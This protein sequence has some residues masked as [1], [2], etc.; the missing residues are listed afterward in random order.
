MLG[1]LAILLVAIFLPGGGL[2]AI[3]LHRWMHRTDRSVDHDQI[4]AY[5]TRRA[6]QAIRAEF[7][8]MKK[9]S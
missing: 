3:G 1:K 6:I 5:R 2:V 9:M 7:E 4:D 8:S